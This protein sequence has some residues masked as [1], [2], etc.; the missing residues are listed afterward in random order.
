VPSRREMGTRVQ[1]R[2]RTRDAPFAMRRARLREGLL[3]G[4]HSG[5]SSRQIGT[6]DR[7]FE[8]R[9]ERP[10]R[11][12][13]FGRAEGLSSSGRLESPTRPP[14]PQRPARE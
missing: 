11:N 5:G 8:G 1:G 2:E 3:S 10:P 12:R 6:S 9:T 4:L 13:I 14:A 7:S